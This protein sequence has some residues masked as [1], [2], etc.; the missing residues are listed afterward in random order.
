MLLRTTDYMPTTL[1]DILRSLSAVDEDDIP[2]VTAFL[3]KCLALNPNLRASA[4]ELLG[5]SKLKTP[6]P[7]FIINSHLLLKLEACGNT[8]LTYSKKKVLPI[9]YQ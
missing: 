6:A 3:R 8:N 7:I 9:L 1:E 2:G 5:Y 4:Q